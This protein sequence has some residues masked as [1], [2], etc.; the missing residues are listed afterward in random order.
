MGSGGCAK[1]GKSAAARETAEP[2]GE[3]AGPDATGTDP[4]PAGTGHT[5]GPD[6]GDH[7]PDPVREPWSG[8][9]PADLLLSGD[10]AGGELG[11]RVVW[12]GDTAWASAPGGGGRVLAVEGGPSFS[13][14]DPSAHLGAA[15]SDWSDGVLAG[16]WSRDGG[17]EGEGAVYLLSADHPGGV[18]EAD[19]APVWVVE[20]GATGLVLL[21]EGAGD[22][23]D[24]WL[25][26]R[27]RSA[28]DRGTV[29]LMS[30]EHQ[31][32]A[33]WIG[34]SGGNLAGGA[35]AVA[36]LD[37]D[38]L[39]DL[40][41]GAWGRSGFSGSVYAVSAPFDGGGAIE[42]ADRRWDGDAW[43]LAG[44]ALASGDVDGDG[45]DDVVVGAFGDTRT[46]TGS[47]AF[48]VVSATAPGGA[49]LE[50]PDHRLGPS[51]D[52]H[53]GGA[54]AV[55]DLDGD[56]FADI[57]AGAPDHSPEGLRGAGLARVY[58]GPV[59]GTGTAY[60]AEVAVDATS[61][62]RGLGA[63]MDLHPEAG[64]LLGAP[65]TEDGR[66]CVLRVEPTPRLLP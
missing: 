45:L 7:R 21:G 32:E 3:G 35:V 24:G 18:V 44:F 60:D 30:A 58:Y 20:S 63:S 5:G 16:A 1:R 37:G 43:A 22:V 53:F 47:G 31:V 61:P 42:D 6:S 11:A 59:E 57:A 13:A 39:R 23:P 52:A 51:A 50:L 12:S 15:L 46:A 64:W 2:A 34:E 48:T 55:A 25:L 65:G 66:G 40:V 38:G 19:L 27:P 14:S 49:L 56:G 41:V 9:L 17:G 4:T 36:D 26:G 62:L 28:G 29:R 10:T 54:L 33:E 8:L